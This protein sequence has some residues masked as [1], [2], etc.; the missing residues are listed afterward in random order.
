MYNFLFSFQRHGKGTEI[1]ACGA[2][3]E[4]QWKENKKH[5]PGIKKLESGMVETQVKFYP[6]VQP[7]LFLFIYC[8]KVN[9]S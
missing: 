9:N 3:Y 6:R 7:V 8:A 2:I 4:G 1:S 5:G